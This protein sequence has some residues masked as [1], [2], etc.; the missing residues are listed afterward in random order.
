MET[1]KKAKPKN[2]TDEY[3]WLLHRPPPKVFS[4]RGASLPESGLAEDS[5][6]SSLGRRIR[7]AESR[8]SIASRAS[9]PSISERVS[10][11][12]KKGITFLWFSGFFPNSKNLDL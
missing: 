11:S 8:E 4:K 10:K 5:P 12:V 2:Y 7:N 3:Y 9:T 1:F 6:P